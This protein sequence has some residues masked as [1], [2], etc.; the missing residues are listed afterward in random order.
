M[1]SFRGE[2]S[3]VAVT[4]VERLRAA[5]GKRRDQ[6]WWA[7]WASVFNLQDRERRALGLLKRY[8]FLPL[9]EKAILDVG[10]GNG[11][12]IQQL[13]RW[14]ARPEHVTGIDLLV[15]RLAQARRRV[16]ARVHLEAGNAAELPFPTASFDLVLQSTVFTS[17][18]GQELR[19]K[20]GSEMLRVLKPDGLILWYDFHVNNPW[21]PDVRR[22]TRWEIYELFPG[23][24]I[25]LRRI[26]L[27]P[28]LTGWV[29]PRSWLLTYALS[30]IPLLCTHYLGVITK[31]VS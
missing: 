21:N 9:G 10:C 20:I 4:E 27:A 29:A 8:G 5:F 6:P 26:T 3:G 17:V 31:R 24:R 16:P 7:S 1:T 14:G 18:L 22:V 2:L 28:P 25:D 30:R 15:D 19:R 11:G 12:W 23:C 13:I